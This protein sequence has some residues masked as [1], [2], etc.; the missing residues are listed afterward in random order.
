LFDFDLTLSRQVMALDG[1]ILWTMRHTARTDKSDKIGQSA[2][3]YVRGNFDPTT[4][5]VNL[6][7][8]SK[9]DPNSV[10]VMLDVYKLQI[11]ADGKKLTGA[12]RNGGKWN[13]K[14]DLSR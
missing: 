6:T 14:V 12:A 10:L 8:Y 2:T 9:E 1:S 5:T 11:S 4:G 7:G 13:G 3:E